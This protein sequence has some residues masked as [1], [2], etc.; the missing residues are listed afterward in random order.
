MVPPILR[1]L[2]GTFGLLDRFQVLGDR[3]ILQ[4]V[5]VDAYLADELSV[6]LTDLTLTRRNG[7]QVVLRGLSGDYGCPATENVL[8]R[9]VFVQQH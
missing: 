5:Q 9:V 1:H 2:N 3:T 6:F 4:R 8:N 7:C